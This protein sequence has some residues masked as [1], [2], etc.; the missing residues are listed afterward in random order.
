MQASSVILKLVSTN[1]F[2]DISLLLLQIIF[3]KTKSQSLLSLHF[4]EVGGAFRRAQNL[5]PLD[6]QRSLIWK[7]LDL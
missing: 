6:L 5:L 7:Q 3:P 4:P 1:V 2:P